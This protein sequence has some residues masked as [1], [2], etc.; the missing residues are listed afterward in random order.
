MPAVILP[1][2]TSMLEPVEMDQTRRDM[3][4]HG[5]NCRSREGYSEPPMSCGQCLCDREHGKLDFTD[6]EHG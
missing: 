5:Q 2:G 3:E 1:V 4:E 6:E